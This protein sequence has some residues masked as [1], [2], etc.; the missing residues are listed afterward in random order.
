MKIFSLKKIWKVLISINKEKN[1]YITI[2]TTTLKY[3]GIYFFPGHFS[4]HYLKELIF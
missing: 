3:F 1:H 4:M 2:K